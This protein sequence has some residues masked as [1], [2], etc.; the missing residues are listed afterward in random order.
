MATGGVH[1]EHEDHP[2]I[3][4]VGDHPDRS[5]SPGYRRS[6]ALMVE[7]VQRT[8][9]WFF[10]PR[11]YQDHHGGGIWLKDDT[12]WLLVFGSAGIEWS[13]Q[14][15]ADPAKVDLLR[16]QANRVVA[17][18]P[19]TVPGYEALGYHAAAGLLG[20]PIADADAVAAWTDGIFNASVALPAGAHT[21]V[22]PASAGYHHYPKP[23]VDIATFKYDDFAL[24]VAD[25]DDNPVAVTPVDRRGS[26]NGAVRIVWADPRTALGRQVLDGEPPVLPDTH[27]LARAAFA[28]QT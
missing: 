25:E 13:A 2:W 4:N 21:G 1:T 17:A 14:F 8:Q 16:T 27:P 26:G 3:I 18:F 6:R 22:L 20:T 7:L 5:D 19:D 11:P 15:C 12:G 28:H 9:P 24:F 23:I 10:G